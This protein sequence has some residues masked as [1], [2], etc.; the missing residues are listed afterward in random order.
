MRIALVNPPVSS[1]AVWVRE[2]RCQQFDIWGTPFPPLSLAYILGGVSQI[3]GVEGRIFDPSAQHQPFLG[4]LDEI[5]RFSPELM[6][7]ATATP[8]V[9]SDLGWYVVEIK[10]HLPGIKVCAIGI[11]VS[12]LPDATLRSFPALDFAVIGEPELPVFQLVTR[13]QQRQNISNV[14]GVAF[15][16]ADLICVN[17]KATPLDNLDDLAAPVWTGINFRDYMMPIKR[18][19]FLLIGFERGCPFSCRFC[20]AHAYYGKKVRKRGVASLLAEIERYVAAGVCDFLFWAEVFSLDR[21]YLHDFLTGL[22]ESGLAGKIK[23]VSNSR[24]DHLDQETIARMAKTGCWQLALGLEFGSNQVLQL[25][26]K[27]GG[28][29]VEQ[30]AR[31][32]RWCRQAGIAAD[33]HFI[34]GFPGETERT[35]EDTIR[36]ASSIPLTFAHFYN[37]TPFPGSPL[38]QEALEKGWFLRQDEW[39]RVHQAD[40]LLELPNLSRETVGRYISRAYRK[41][42]SDPRVMVRILRV[43]DNLR[44]VLS[45]IFLGI[46]FVRAMLWK[47]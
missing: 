44:E 40:Y 1:G 42:Y 38:Y 41:F 33:G 36:F 15:R 11:H 17:E 5:A 39:D 9:A 6:V 23:W 35:L 45:I 21:Q 22:E 19:P 47:K 18:R 32:V 7:V 12:V 3:S 28:A 2:G 20:A 13:L 16:D 8:T 14:A 30:G 25:A 10:K 31:V 29:T 37:A 46:R 34:M 26:G 4:H 27:G 43:A 24:V